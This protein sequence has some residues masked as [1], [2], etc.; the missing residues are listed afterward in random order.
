MTKE[1][2]NIA[3]GQ[4]FIHSIAC[5]R[6][7]SLAAT[8]NIDGIVSLYDLKDRKFKARFSNHN[9]AVRTLAFDNSS[10]SMVSAGEDLHIFVSDVETQ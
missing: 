4:K 6:S 7:G 3:D 10:T 5:S 9:L 2:Q 8:G 1:A